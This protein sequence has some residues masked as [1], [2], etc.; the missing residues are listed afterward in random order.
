MFRRPRKIF[1]VKKDNIKAGL[2]ES[3]R[4]IKIPVNL[5]TVQFIP[6]STK[7]L[8]LEHSQS[9]TKTESYIYIA[10]KNF[11]VKKAIYFTMK[12][13][14]IGT[15]VDSNFIFFYF[16]DSIFLMNLRSKLF[17]SPLYMFKPKD[18]EKLISINLKEITLE[19]ENKILKLSFNNL[20]VIMRSEKIV[21]ELGVVT[22]KYIIISDLM[23]EINNSMSEKEFIY[24]NTLKKLE[25]VPKAQIAGSKFLILPGEES[26]KVLCYHKENNLIKITD[27]LNNKLVFTLLIEDEEVI[28]CND[29]LKEG[30]L[31]LLIL[32]P[33][34]VSL[35]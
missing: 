25:K 24:M 31:Y 23:I 19:N 15:I 6:K 27:S 2:Y 35:Y 8:L 5:S 20:R 3:D 14:F 12:L 34:L 29:F 11:I 10:N 13:D 18:V 22:D 28:F 30:K 16:N 33:I 4:F 21:V 1:H 26:Q 7:I 9:N 32:T 17:P